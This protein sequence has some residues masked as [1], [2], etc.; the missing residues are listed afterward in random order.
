[1]TARRYLDQ[2]LRLPLLRA[3]DALATHGSMLKASAALGLSQPA[4]TKS[5]HEL[6]D[7]L[8]LRIF[9]RHPRGVYPTAAGVVLVR[10]ARR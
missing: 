8:Q 4:L 9:H 6:E 3:V 1:M 10:S 5:L 2:R 7:L